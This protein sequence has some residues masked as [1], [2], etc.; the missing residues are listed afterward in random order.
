[1]F[2]LF[3][4]GFKFEGCAGK[5][6]NARAQ[7]KPDA[8]PCAVMKVRPRTCSKDEQKNAQQDTKTHWS[9]AGIS[10]FGAKEQILNL[11]GFHYLLLK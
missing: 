2:P 1:M 5:R 11:A 3:G 10:I 8:S 6:G 9:P 7:K 4:I